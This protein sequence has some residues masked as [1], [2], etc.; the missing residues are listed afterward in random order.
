MKGQL[1]SELVVP[2]MKSMTSPKKLV[3]L[4]I[5]AVLIAVYLP[6]FIVISTAAA[7]S[8]GFGRKCSHSQFL[9]NT[10]AKGSNGKL[11]QCSGSGISQTKSGEYKRYYSWV[12][13]KNPTLT[14][15]AKPGE[16]CFTPF[17]IVSTKFGK[18]K[19]QPVRVRPPVFMWI[20]Q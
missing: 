5:S 2:R 18:L 16:I 20:K 4:T 11:F 19:C 7:E 12:Q 13:I 14:S 9:S 10:T 3:S 8:P 15:S 17:E 6:V 1:Q